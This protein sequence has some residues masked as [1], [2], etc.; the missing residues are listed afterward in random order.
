MAALLGVVFLGVERG[1]F[2]AIGLS[3]I[4]HLRQ[5]YHPKDVV[6]A[7][8]GTHWRA[9]GPAMGLETEP[10][11]IVYRFEAALFF[12]NADYFAAQLHRLIEQAPHPVRWLVLDLVSMDDIDYTGGL[13]LAATLKTLRSQGLTIALAQTED[14][15][16]ELA[17]LGI[18]TFIGADWVFNSV[19]AAMNAFRQDGRLDQTT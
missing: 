9:P 12:A 18:V 13:T 11:L 5:E 7:P 2:L 8:D 6:L 3:V 16:D 4:D 15:A 1:I 17:R 10:G 14:V 19:S